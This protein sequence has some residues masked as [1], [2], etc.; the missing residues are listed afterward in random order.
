MGRTEAIA[1]SIVLAIV[2]GARK[3]SRSPIAFILTLL[4]TI[5]SLYQ[6]PLHKHRPDVFANLRQNYWKLNEDDYVASFRPEEGG[7]VED[8]L[9]SMGDMG[10]SGSVSTSWK[11]FSGLLGTRFTDPYPN[12]RLSLPP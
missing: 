10:F 11:N 4:S 1:R 5:F 9:S 2:N 12:A 8:V 6:L 7:K 3:R